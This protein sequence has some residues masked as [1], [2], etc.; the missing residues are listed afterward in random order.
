MVVDQGG[1]GD[2]IEDD[3]IQDILITCRCMRDKN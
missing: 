3:I 2:I 1:G